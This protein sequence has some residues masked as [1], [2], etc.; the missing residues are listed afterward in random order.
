MATKEKN[1]LTQAEK[2]VLKNEK[3]QEQTSEEPVVKKP[4]Y[5]RF[6][7]FL[8]RI[9]DTIAFYITLP[10]RKDEVVVDTGDL[11]SN[12]GIYS[13]AKKEIDQQQEELEKQKNKE[14]DI[15]EEHTAEPINIEGADNI[16]VGDEHA[17]DSTVVDEETVEPIV[18]K[19]N[20]NGEHD[21]VTVDDEHTDATLIK[22]GVADEVLNDP[23]GVNP[24]QVNNDDK[25]AGDSQPPVPAFNEILNEAPVAV[26]E[27]EFETNTCD[28]FADLQ[29]SISA[30]DSAVQLSAIEGGRLVLAVV[31]NGKTEA[32]VDFTM[33][34]LNADGLSECI[35]ILKETATNIVNQME[36]NANIIKLYLDE[37]RVNKMLTELDQRKIESATDLRVLAQQLC[38]NQDGIKNVTMGE[39]EDKLLFHMNVGGYDAEKGECTEDVIELNLTDSSIVRNREYTDWST[40]S[41]NKESVKMEADKLP[42]SIKAIY[43]LVQK[44]A[45][46]AIFNSDRGAERADEF[47]IGSEVLNDYDEAPYQNRQHKKNGNHRREQAQVKAFEEAMNSGKKLQ[48]KAEKRQERK[49]EN[50]AKRKQEQFLKEQDAR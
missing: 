32:S 29:A 33:D 4:W 20:D 47:P 43:Q 48:T 10:F 8:T 16:E 15:V 50:A 18:I 14:K 28:T 44:D 34:E 38:S 6:F 17:D 5:Q 37:E 39:M 42:A 41:T 40:M 12:N 2:E 31:D 49:A 36:A 24:E 1:N 26:E 27:A 19:K 21:D 23:S 11:D 7:D 13:K 22:D 9:V 35:G 25:H 3:K 45:V 46:K 30:I